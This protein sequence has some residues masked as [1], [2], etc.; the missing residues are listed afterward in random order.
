MSPVFCCY[1][2]IRKYWC[3]KCT[4]THY[5]SKV[6]ERNEP[7]PNSSFSWS[8]PFTLACSDLK[9]FQKVEFRHSLDSTSSTSSFKSLPLFNFSILASCNFWSFQSFLSTTFYSV[10]KIIKPG[11]TLQTT[12]LWCHIFGI[13]MLLHPGQ[14]SNSRRLP[15]GRMRSLV[16]CVKRVDG[17][18]LTHVYTSKR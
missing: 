11:K 1:E 6:L 12:M 4:H 8:T 17:L 16:T 10:Q 2:A 3:T 14:D 18:F 5:L 9:L 15:W 13:L 7:L